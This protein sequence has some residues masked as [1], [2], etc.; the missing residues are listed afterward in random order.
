MTL[1]IYTKIALMLEQLKVTKEMLN[2]D[3]LRPQQQEKLKD[4][5]DILR[6]E[7]R[8]MYFDLFKVISN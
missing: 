8:G 7:L 4:Q 5:L 3:T 6:K 1:D 2:D